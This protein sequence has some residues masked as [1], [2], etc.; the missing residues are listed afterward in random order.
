MFTRN[1]SNQRGRSKSGGRRS[2]AVSL[3]DRMLAHPDNRQPT[4]RAVRRERRLQ[5]IN[6]HPTK[7]GAA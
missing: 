6:D 4:E 2:Q 1:D 7:G 3:T 5:N